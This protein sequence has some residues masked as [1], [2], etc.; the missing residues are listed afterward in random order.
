[1]AISTIKKPQ[2]KATTVTLAFSNSIATLAN[3]SGYTL[4]GLYVKERPTNDNGQYSIDGFSRRSSGEY[5]VKNLYS[6]LNASTKAQ[7]IWLADD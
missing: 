4:I 3:E 6:G 5:I 2:I 1:M 7:A